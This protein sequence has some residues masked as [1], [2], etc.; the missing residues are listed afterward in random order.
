MKKLIDSRSSEDM[1]KKK[2]DSRLIA[3]W[4]LID[5]QS[6]DGDGLARMR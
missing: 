2:L 6:A 1:C 5:F 4:D 3:I